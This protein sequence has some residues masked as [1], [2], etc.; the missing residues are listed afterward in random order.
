M[1]ESSAFGQSNVSRPREVRAGEVAVVSLPRHEGSVNE[2]AAIV[3]ERDDA[4]LLAV[5][6]GVG[7]L[8]GGDRAARRALE[9][10]A[11]G[12]LEDARVED[13]I[14]RANDAVRELRGPACTL[15]VGTLREG[16]LRTFHVGDSQALLLG[17]RGRIK[18]ITMPHSVVGHGSEAGLL[19]PADAAGHPMLHV[20]T[21]VLGEAALRMERARWGQL[22]PLDTLLLASDGLFD[23]LPR[24]EIARLARRRP[25]DAMV[26]GL[27]EAARAEP[28][29]PLDD[30]TIVAF[31]PR[32]PKKRRSKSPPQ[33]PPTGSPPPPG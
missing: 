15:V 6:D 5:A 27:A 33:A 26:Q 19:D 31:R 17:G 16:V 3:R 32:R 1:N 20:V 12:F 8:P 28:D 29:A 2:D 30:L 7:G 13:A 24:D 10:L 25:L 22:A 21:N 14:E 11:A 9:V 4:L 23:A 18:A